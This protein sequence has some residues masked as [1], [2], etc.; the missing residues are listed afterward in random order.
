MPSIRTWTLYRRVAQTWRN[1]KTLF[2]NPILETKGYCTTCDRESR[3]VAHETWLRDHFLCQC[4]GSIPRERA[5]MATIA[6]FYPQ[7]RDL[8]IHESSPGNRGASVRLE[9][10]CRTYTASHYF[11][12]EALG[13]QVGRYRCEDLE[14]LTFADESIDLHVSQDVIEHVFDPS[15]VFR[16]IAR[17]L[18]PGGAHIFTVPLTKQAEPSRV[19]AQRSA[20]GSIEHLESPI[21]HG[22]PIDAEGSLVTVDWGYDLCRHIFDACGLYTYLVKTDDLSRGIRAEYIEVLVTVKPGE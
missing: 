14:R 15:A 17:T 5:L 19:R 10:E 6:D 12:N 7:W 22:N 4:C 18:R 21:Y 1:R 13:S 20:N 2:R 11:P 16:E 9:R 8:V 3:F